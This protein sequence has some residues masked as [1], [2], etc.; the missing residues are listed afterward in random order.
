MDEKL[1]QITKEHDK[2]E[3]DLQSPDVLGNPEKL[4]KLSKQ[5]N[6]L[7]EVIM[8]NKKLQETNI[9]VCLHW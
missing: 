4:S 9:L 7:N 8:K 3:R 5:Y 2:L 1:E 6:E